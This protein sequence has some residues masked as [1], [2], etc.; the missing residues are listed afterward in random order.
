MGTEHITLDHGVEHKPSSGANPSN[1]KLLRLVGSKDNDACW[2]G[3]EFGVLNPNNHR[4]DQCFTYPLSEH[5]KP[6]VAK[7]RIANNIR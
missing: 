6:E 4:P 3:L 1:S 7:R 5:Y 2:I